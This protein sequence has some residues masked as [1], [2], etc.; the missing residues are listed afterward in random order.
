MNWWQQYK[1]TSQ[2]KAEES[3]SFLQYLR[4]DLNLPIEIHQKES[5]SFPS[6]IGD[7]KKDLFLE[8]LPSDENIQ[9]SNFYLLQT[10]DRISTNTSEIFEIHQES[11][12]SGIRFSD[13][14]VNL[15]T[16]NVFC[17]ADLPTNQILSFG[18]GAS[19]VC[20]PLFGFD[21]LPHQLGV[22]PSELLLSMIFQWKN[23]FQQQPYFRI[24]LL[25]LDSNRLTKYE[26]SA[27]EFD[28]RT[29]AKLPTIPSLQQKNINTIVYVCST[30]TDLDDVH[31]D[32]CYYSNASFKMNWY[33]ANSNDGIVE[34]VFQKRSTIFSK[35]ISFANKI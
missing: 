5:R 1:Q 2:L 9:W 8:L 24:P 17:I 29:T 34:K 21:S 10:A 6:I 35:R 26:D 16:Q 11:F 28:N 33:N 25:L 32:F 22:C 7:K 20:E 19:K 3:I 15:N 14:L 12:D 31:E 23:E 13:E 4:L 30:E 27:I 18:I